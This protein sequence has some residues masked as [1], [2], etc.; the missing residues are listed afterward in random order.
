MSPMEWDLNDS[1]S[2]NSLIKPIH[3]INITTIPIPVFW[4]LMRL[5]SPTISQSMW[6]GT[7]MFLN[8]S[9]NNLL[10][11]GVQGA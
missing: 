6:S 9:R 2:T 4:F 7:W 5:K 11:L 1:Q 3:F 10:P 8:H